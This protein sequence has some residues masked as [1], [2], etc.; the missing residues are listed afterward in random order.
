MAPLCLDIEELDADIAVLGVPYDMGTAVRGGARYGPRGVREAST[1]NCYACEGWYDPIRE[2]TFLGDKWRIVDCGDVDVMH[3]LYEQSFKN[4]EEAVR[5]ILAKGAIPFVI[6]GDHAISIPIIKA[7][8]A[9]EDICIVQFDAHMDFTY[10]PAGVLEGQGSP[11]RRASERKHVTK[12][13]QIGIRGIGSSQISDF[14]D[15][16]RFGSI[17]ATSKQVRESGVQDIIDVIP[18]AKGYYITFDIDCLDPSL[19]MG[20]GSPQPFGL[21][22]EEVVPVIEA[23]AYKGDIV[24]FDM[25][26]VSPPYDSNQMT[27]M[28]AAQIMLDAMSFTL[29]GREKR[30]SK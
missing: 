27:S 3:T 26:E 14:E 13:M 29:R 11:M 7:Y 21:Y 16:R 12:M 20:C 15:A 18:D 5:K 17:I 22:Y 10:A 19:A 23:V 30:A 1:F 25:V 6:G 8:D 9:F 24:G 28:Y 4:C 2:T